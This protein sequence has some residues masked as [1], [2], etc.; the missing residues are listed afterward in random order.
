MEI[1]PL[2][3]YLITRLDCIIGLCC[4]AIVVSVAI[5]AIILAE[6]YINTG[7]ISIRPCKTLLYIICISAL[8]ASCLPSTKNTI[9]MYLIPKIANNVQL[10][11]INTSMLNLMKNYLES[12]KSKNKDG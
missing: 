5:M 10:K 12:E 3:I 2:T 8:I 4:L 1:T 7:N 11:D 6:H 9:A